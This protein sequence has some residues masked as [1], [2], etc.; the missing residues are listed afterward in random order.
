MVALPRLSGQEV[1]TASELADA[2]PAKR[3]SSFRVLFWARPT[4]QDIRIHAEIRKRL[5]VVHRER[6]T[7]WARL[8]R[9]VGAAVA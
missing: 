4:E 1:G 8:R 2:V 5:L 3:G 6:N 7:L 9:L